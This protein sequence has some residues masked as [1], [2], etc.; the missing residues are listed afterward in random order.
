MCYNYIN[1][2]CIL[3]IL[4]S[5]LYLQMNEEQFKPIMYNYN[6]EYNKVSVAPYFNPFHTYIQP[7]ELDY[8]INYPPEYKTNASK[9][10]LANKAY[11]CS[12][13]DKSY[14]P[15]EPQDCPDSSFTYVD[16]MGVFVHDDKYTNYNYP[17]CIQ[18]KEST[19]YCYSTPFGNYLPNVEVL[20]V[21]R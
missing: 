20:N 11:Y 6:P 18:L 8:K 9:S 19:N 4:A 10:W 17:G 3:F 16:N 7:S 21:D 2:I 12:M 15:K 14:A 5:I 1:T 13:Y